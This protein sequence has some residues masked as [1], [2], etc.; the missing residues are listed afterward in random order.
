MR[1]AEKVAIV[2]GSGFGIGRATALLLAAEGARMVV[3]DIDEEAGQE[4]AA[5]I[6]AKGGR[7]FFVHVDVTSAADAE[8]MVRRAVEAFGRLDIL[9]NNAGLLRM[10][11]VDETSEDDWRLVIDTNLTGVFLCSKAAIRQMRRQGGGCI[12]NIAS[13]AGMVG[14]PRS[15]AYCASKGGVVL[16]TKAMALDHEQDS[17]RVNAICPGA[18]DTRLMEGKW[19]FE[20]AEDMVAARRDYEAALPLGRMLH[21]KEVAHQVLFLASHKSYFMTGHCLVI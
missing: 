2:T 21:P 6:E 20:G 11:A 7:A 9:V 17:I 19:R 13:G 15:A 1:L 18:V 16:L 14:V 10:G 12:V 4:S 5:Q 3:A 8:R